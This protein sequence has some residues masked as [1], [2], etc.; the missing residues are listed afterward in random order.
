MDKTFI[1]VK[2]LADKLSVS[3]KTIY[4]M[5]NDHRIP[6]AIKIGGQWRF[7]IN[8]VERW[9]ETQEQELIIKTNYHLKIIDAIL[10]GTILYRLHGENCDEVLTE[11]L[12][13]L[14]SIEELD[15]LQLKSSI[16]YRESIVSSSLNGIAYMQPSFE[17]PVFYKKTMIII[18]FLEETKDF[19]SIDGIDTKVIFLTLPANKIEQA[20]IDIKLQRLS[21]DEHFV[22][23]IKKEP[24]RRELLEFI[25]T[26]EDKILK[27]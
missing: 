4:R 8:E 19:E 27:D 10:N 21:M 11:L 17:K 9:I 15:I 3:D 26:L 20:I 1:T 14:P 13:M 12:N 23:T 22:N 18:G 7:N 16:L 5:I 24:C 2:D 6:F 25:K